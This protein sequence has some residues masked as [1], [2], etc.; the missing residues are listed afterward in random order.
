[1]PLGSL[2]LPC[3][4]NK[5]QEY[6]QTKA[7]HHAQRAA[8]YDRVVA[9]QKHTAYERHLQGYGAEAAVARWCDVNFYQDDNQF[10]LQDIGYY[11]QVKWRDPRLGRFDLIVN[12]KKNGFKRNPATYAYVLTS[13][14][15]PQFYLVGWVGGVHVVNKSPVVSIK[16]GGVA[17]W[18]VPLEDLRQEWNVLKLILKS[19][20][21]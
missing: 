19:C 18:I 13:G 6:I 17:R 3:L 4:N 8:E 1:M 12:I 7:R 20:K 14:V 10:E 9:S 2:R 21:A 11:G 5:D 15:F 16:Y